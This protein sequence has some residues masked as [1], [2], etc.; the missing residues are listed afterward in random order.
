MSRIMNISAY[1]KKVTALALAVVLAVASVSVAFVKMAGSTYANPDYTT[2]SSFERVNPV[3]TETVEP[4]TAREAL[5][6]P[7]ALRA[8]CQLPAAGTGFVQTEPQAGQDGD[9]D[10]YWWGYVA[11]RE[12]DEDPFAFNP[13]PYTIYT[14]N[15]ADGAKAYRVH[16]TYNGANE[17]FYACNAAGSLT[18]V[19]RFVPV[20]WIGG[21]NAGTEGTYTFTAKLTEVNYSGTLPTA[22]VT[23]D[24]AASHVCDEDCGHGNCWEDN[25]EEEPAPECTC[26]QA[27][28]GHAPRECPLWNP[29]CTCPEGTSGHTNTACPYWVPL[30]NCACGISSTNKPWQHNAGCHL[31]AAPSLA[32][33]ACGCEGTHD[34]TNRDCI[35]YQ[36]PLIMPMSLNGGGAN[37]KLGDDYMRTNTTTS[38][39]AGYVDFNSY[40]I[41]GAWK[42][43]VNTIWMN[44]AYNKYAWT[45]AANCVSSGALAWTY[46]GGVANQSTGGGVSTNAFRI[47]VANASREW[48]VYSGEQLRYALLNY[49]SGDTISIRWNI[50]LNGNTADWGQVSVS[51]KNLT[52]EGNNRTI[53]N[54]GMTQ[55]SNATSCAFLNFNGSARLSV[56][57][58]TFT[59][60]KLVYRN[61]APLS[62]AIF[63]GA[64]TARML[65]SDTEFNNILLYENYKSGASGLGSSRVACVFS[66]QSSAYSGSSIF[67][68]AFVNGSYMYGA[69]HVSAL[70][71]TI[72]DAVL[73]YCFA[74]DTLICATGGHLAPLGGCASGYALTNCFASTEIYAT[75]WACG[76]MFTTSSPTTS[77]CY[78]TGK[79]EGFERIGGFTAHNVTRM[80]NCYSTM[81]VG[82]RSESTNL[83]GF[84]VNVNDGVVV[85]CYSAGEVGNHTT[86]L[87]SPVNIGGFENGFA[88]SYPRT[89]CY[90]DKQTSAMREWAAGNTKT[91]AGIRG[92]LTSTTAKGGTGLASGTYGSSTDVGFKGFSNN[93]LWL[94]SAQHYPQLAVFGNP[95]DANWGTAA[96]AN[97]V[98]A[99]SRA[100]TGTVFLDTWDTGYDWDAQGLRTAAKVSYNRNV[101][102]TT[103]RGGQFTYDT[104]REIVSDFTKT[105]ASTFTRMVSGGPPAEVTKKD[106]TKVTTKNHIA[107]SGNAGTVIDPGLEW[108]NIA[109]TYSNQTGNRPIRLISYMKVDA[110]PDKS[111]A[112][113]AKYNHRSDVGLTMMDTITDN[114]VVGLHDTQLWST[115]KEQGYPNNTK[116][117]AVPTTATKFSA[118]VNAWVYTEIWRAQKNAAGAYVM[119]G[120]EYTPGISVSVTGA[121]TGSNTTIDEQKWNGQ[122]PLYTDTSAG[123]KYIVTYYWMLE[124]GRYREDHKVI[125]I[126]PGKYDLKV[127]VRNMN[128][129]TANTTALKPA[130]A[131]DSGA[132]TGYTFAGAGSY[133]QALQN[134]YT[135]NTSAAWA[136]ANAANTV[137]KIEIIMT[138]ADGTV[139]G[140][141]FVTG[142]NLIEGAQIVVP[143]KYDYFTVVSGREVTAQETVNITYTVKKDASGGY[144]L[145]FNKMANPIPY[146]AASVLLNKD[147]T[148]IPSTAHAYINNMDY[149]VTVNL[150]VHDVA[151]LLVEKRLAAPAEE[152]ETFVFRV[153]YM[154]NGTSAGATERTMYAVI[155]IGHGASGG[156]ALFKDM[157]VGWY[158][159]TEMDSNWRFGFVA[160]ALTADNPGASINAANRSVTMWSNSNAGTYIFRNN[161]KSAPWVNGKARVKNDM[162]KI[163]GM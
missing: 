18:G 22:E 78:S 134:Q 106:G 139:M 72:V 100:S 41:P 118:S 114:R 66:F 119:S 110:G 117:Y 155:T 28:A 73:N 133:A 6:L 101:G 63:T 70:T 21:Y 141:A 44:K 142:A 84:G 29:E 3:Y 35:L 128:N 20:E 4:G 80:E 160:S 154:G 50:N 77:N 38:G 135:T 54:L 162:P 145:Q 8:V 90:Y 9:Y 147:G 130:A 129:G 31:F 156:S 105:S 92:C 69:D 132:V 36:P 109:E 64:S 53:F 112:A 48:Y 146:E 60:G 137:K 5:R 56:Q 7:A 43:Y 30:A 17:G 143:V 12:K 19:V 34:T 49:T 16:G 68:R 85:N 2:V 55:T 127:N 86:N 113:G 87:N 115:A 108:Y 58:L 107:I 74:V 140:S 45:P 95:A 161:R 111:V 11:P 82:L 121:G 103:H 1:K 57:N 149:H 61:A 99:Y 122:L 71:N 46:G 83:G 37:D 159:V 13:S 10:Y 14:I 15:Y 158:T 81:L 144:Y 52:I 116:Y 32:N 40:S 96:R 153:D 104:V 88:S 25:E 150:Y 39:N 89:N 152:E 151:D 59:S 33:G 51:G 23:V 47:P 131:P 102:T 62:V 76:L 97:M 98:R 123:H 65:M 126:T 157:P 27:A 163:E 24:A 26:D 42:D 93:A 91:A 67:T 94:Y 124:D 136:K 148:G 120:A 125:T 79:I 75:S 138:G